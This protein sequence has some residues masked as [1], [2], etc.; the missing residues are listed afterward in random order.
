MFEELSSVDIMFLGCAIV[1]GGLFALRSIMML[2]GLS[3]DHDGDGMEDMSDSAGE[4]V[5]DF[6]MVTLHGLTAFLLMFGLVGFLLL[7]KDGLGTWV[8]ASAGTAAGLVTMFIIAKIFQ[9]SRKLV[10][11][12]TIYPK[13]AVG[14]SGSVYL[15][16]RPGGVGKVQLTVRN[17][18]KVFDARA[19]DAAAEIKTGAHIKVIGVEDVL[20]VEKT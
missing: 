5:A 11:D 1:G 16:I 10:S 20:V 7:R 19:K 13:D 12:G 14:V 6:K 17:A 15:T 18:L 8:A 9:S 4:P 2:V 3:G